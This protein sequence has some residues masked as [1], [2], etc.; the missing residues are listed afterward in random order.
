M[1]GQ[2]HAPCPAG[3]DEFGVGTLF[4]DPTPEDA[5]ALRVELC[6]LRVVGALVEYAFL[7]RMEDEFLWIEFANFPD[8]MARSGIEQDVFL[9]KREKIRALPHFAG[10]HGIGIFFFP[11]A[12]SRERMEILPIAQIF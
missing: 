11:P 12:T 3:A 9:A 4:G 8:D 10:V 7:L 1:A 5:I 2:S 6:F